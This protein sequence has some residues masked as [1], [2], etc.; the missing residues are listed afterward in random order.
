VRA[1]KLQALQAEGRAVLPL[2]DVGKAFGLRGT[3]PGRGTGLVAVGA[4]CF[5]ADEVDGAT[6][7]EL[8]KGQGVEVLAAVLPN[9]RTVEVMR[10]AE[11]RDAA[12]RAGRIKAR[13]A[14]RGAGKVERS[15]VIAENRR[16]RAVLE[17]WGRGVRGP[18]G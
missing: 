7:G 11:A 12:V 4:K 1:A 15:K 18:R 9:G 17:A 14:G 8:V 13:S 2:D 10:E 16:R 5:E 3:E 6:W